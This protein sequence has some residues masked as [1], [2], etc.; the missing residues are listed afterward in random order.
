[1]GYGKAIVVSP[2]TNAGAPLMTALISLTLLRVVPQPL[3]L[4]GI[5]LGFVAA[6]LLAIE[7]EERA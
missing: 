3:K 4:F 2:L 5:V 6:A 1:M 7:P